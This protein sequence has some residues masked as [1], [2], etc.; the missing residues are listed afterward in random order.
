M[1]GWL[2]RITN[3]VVPVISFVL[4]SVSYVMVVWIGIPSFERIAVAVIVSMLCMLCM[5]STITNLI[6][7]PQISLIIHEETNGINLQL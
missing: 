3:I 4:R 1:F 2:K 7:T 6:L 5:V